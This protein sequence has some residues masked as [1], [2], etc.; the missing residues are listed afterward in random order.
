MSGEKEPQIS[1]GER[2]SKQDDV[3]REG[4][5]PGFTCVTRCRF[6]PLGPST[7]SRPREESSGSPANNARSLGVGMT[8]LNVVL[9]LQGGLKNFDVRRVVDDPSSDRGTL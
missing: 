7:S 9:L 8:F 6:L 1:T 2:R 5:A 3:G 4:S